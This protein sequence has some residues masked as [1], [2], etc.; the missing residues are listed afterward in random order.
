[1]VANTNRNKIKDK[2]M[3]KLSKIIGYSCLS[4]VLL[5]SSCIRDGLDECP[6]E[7]DGS[8]YIRFV[9]DYNMSFEDLFHV[10]ACKMNVYLFDDNGTFLYMLSEDCGIGA[11]FPKGYAM[12]IPVEVKHATRLVAW[13]GLHNETRDVVSMTPGVSQMNDLKVQLK[14]YSGNQ[15]KEKMKPLWHGA[16][17][18]LLPES[19]NSEGEEETVRLKND[20]TTISLTKNS[21]IVRVVMQS[22]ED[23]LRLDINDFKFTMEAVNG[24][25]DCHNNICSNTCW[26]YSPYL[27]YNE[28]NT[29]GIVELNTLRLQADRNNRL[30][31]EH[32]PSEEM[33]LDIDVNKI[34][35]AM[36]AQDYSGMSLQEY[37][38]REDEYKITVFVKKSSAAMGASWVVV[39]VQLN[40]WVDR[41]QDQ[42]GR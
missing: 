17:V 23:N 5:F 21:N 28:D 33:L 30:L 8:S 24:A 25:Y 39:D 13:S 14:Q 11:T 36:K 35:N 26:Y 2:R 42:T 32:T 16:E 31:I 3:D 27:A 41:D 9:Y 15:F 4:I 18:R 38:D 7:G 6:P 40:P 37:M 10:Q 12:K 34:I 19:P 29:C 1:M 20:T 22:V